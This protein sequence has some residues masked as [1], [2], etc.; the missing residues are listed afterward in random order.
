V[1]TNVAAFT[2]IIAWYNLTGK[3][4]IAGFRGMAERAPL[5][6]AGLT[7]AL[8]SLSGMPLFAGF[9]TKF[10]LFQA[11]ASE[12]FLWLSVIAVLMSFLSLYYYLMVIKE[13]YISQPEEEGRLPV[14]LLMNG[15]TVALVTGVFYVGIFPRH[16]FEAA[17]EATKLLFV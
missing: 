14:P 12:G 10:I 16:L 6:A 8:F 1:I 7:A 2:C 3:D 9:F 4:E 15:M 11:V 5:L 17:Q 13:L